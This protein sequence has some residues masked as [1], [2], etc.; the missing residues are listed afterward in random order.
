MKRRITQIVA[1]LA[2]HSSWGPQVK[3]FCN[4]VL[5]CHSCPLAW[6]ACPIGVLV[7]FSGYLALPLLALG[8]VILIGAISGRF[9]CG[10]LCPFGFLQDMLYKIPGKKIRIPEWTR[11]IKYPVLVFMVFLIPLW[12]GGNTQYSFCRICPAATI[13]VSTPAILQGKIDF[14]TTSTVVRYVILGAILALA[15][16]NSRSFCRVLCPIGALLAPLNHVSLWRVKLNGHSCVSCGKCDEVCP[17]EITPSERAKNHTPVNRDH[18]CIVCHDCK[19]ACPLV[20]KEENPVKD[21]PQG[22][23]LSC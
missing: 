7:H 2:F 22:E 21:K 9:F 12:L 11:Y 15:V 6:F 1:L 19:K 13:E 8:T 16:L 17:T 23:E 5:M 3:W 10:W 4:P 20:K 14:L 18:D